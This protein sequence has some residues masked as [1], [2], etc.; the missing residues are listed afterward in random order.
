MTSM[1]LRIY[2]AAIA[3]ICGAA[4]AWSIHQGSTASAWQADARDDAGLI[5]HHQSDVIGALV[6]FHRRSGQ[7]VERCGRHPERGDISACGDVDEVGGH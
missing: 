1:A 6:P 3:L 5:D 7:R 4:V 2:T